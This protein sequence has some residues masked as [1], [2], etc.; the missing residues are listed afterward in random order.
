MNSFL[1]PLNTCVQ[2]FSISPKKKN[3]HIPPILATI[4]TDNAYTDLLSY[5]TATERQEVSEWGFG[6]IKDATT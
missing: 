6:A 3:W 4:S 5:I 1:Y 2:L